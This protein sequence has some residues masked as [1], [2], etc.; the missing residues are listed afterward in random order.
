VA[1]IMNVVAGT[2]APLATLAPQ[3][4]PAVLAA[5]ER[6]LAKKPDERFADVPAFIEALTGRPLQTL[7]AGLPGNSSAAPSVPLSHEEL[8]AATMAPPSSPS[9]SSGAPSGAPP[10]AITTPPAAPKKTSP[11]PWIAGL[12][13]VAGIGA[14]LALR[15]TSPPPPVVAKPAPA[16][17]PPPSVAAPPAAEPQP[18]PEP[19]R[20]Q[21]ASKVEK[22]AP[23][24]AHAEGPLPDDV[25]ADLEG[26][27]KAL[28]AGDTREAKRLA[29]H[30]LQ[31][32]RTSRA[33]VILTRAACAEHDLTNARASLRNVAGAGRA[34]VIQA[35]A[36]AGLDL[37]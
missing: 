21:P 12:I 11:L 15:G 33:F 19:A 20:E 37:R 6:A 23:A 22:K 7:N 26:A 35:C 4:P 3:T 31:G 13:V 1:V 5:V 32:Q 16:A 9:L 17:P 8:M 36:S 10:I 18:Q 30:S 27:E 34:A 24:R 14:T 25:R 28:A 2:P 29:Q